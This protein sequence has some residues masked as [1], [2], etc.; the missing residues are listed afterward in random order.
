MESKLPIEL[1]PF[2]PVYEKQ[3]IDFIVVIQQKEFN[4]SITIVNSDQYDIRLEQ[5]AIK[6]RFNVKV[7]RSPV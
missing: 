5:T 3:V 6:S 1:R 2:S 7:C 4:I